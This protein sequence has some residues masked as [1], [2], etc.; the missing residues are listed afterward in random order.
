[1]NQT[2][3]LQCHKELGAKIVPFAGYEMPL[4]YDLG[5]IKEHMWVRNSCGVFDVSHMGQLLI[6]GSNVAKLLSIITPTNFYDQKLF[7]SKYTTFLN[8]KCTIV[9][10]LIV[11]K[12]A[13]DKYFLVVNAA[14]KNHDVG[15]IS[16]FLANYDCQIEILDRSLLAVQGPKSERIL[17]D[18]LNVDLDQQKY[19]QLQI[20][21]YLGEDIFVSRTGYTGEDGFEISISNQNAVLLWQELINNTNVKAIGLGA[22]DSLRLEMGYPLYGHDLSEEINLGESSLKWIITSNENFL[23]KEYCNFTPSKKRVGIRLLDKGVARE[24]MSVCDLEGNQVGIL[25]SSGYSPTLKTSIGQAYINSE[26]SKIGQ[27]IQVNIR[28]RYKMAEVT[29]INFLTPH[30]KK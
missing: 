25:T 23:G 22:R 27:K 2:A 30:T 28:G 24:G 5:I 4:Y 10:D 8:D 20:V 18:I 19:M 16:G 1:M 14:R 7:S 17:S 6:T 29:K 11:T 3:L 9:D 15:L 21:S 13:D 12:I 26:N